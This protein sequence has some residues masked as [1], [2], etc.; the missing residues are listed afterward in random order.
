MRQSVFLRDE[1]MK[2]PSPLT[3]TSSTGSSASR[4]A[5]SLSPPAA[6]SSAAAACRGMA[7]KRSEPRSRS[8]RLQVPA[9]PRTRCARRR[10]AWSSRSALRPRT[11]SSNPRTM[12]SPLTT[13]STRR[14]E[15]PS[16]RQSARLVPRPP[17]FGVAV[18]SWKRTRQIDVVTSQSDGRL[19][20]DGAPEGRWSVR[21]GDP[22]S[23]R[24][25]RGSRASPTTGSACFASNACLGGR[26]IVQHRRRDREELLR[27]RRI[28]DVDAP[29]ATVHVIE[30]EPHLV[31]A[32]E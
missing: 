21:T 11:G 20:R 4:T 30:E 22:R 31:V 1:R 8:R 12:R 15:A 7:P 29:I 3:H 23:G 6:G 5:R 19:G 24:D 9:S 32:R 27:Q 28:T 14:P 17:Q 13:V 26:E 2:S 16:A 10:T 25:H 18:P